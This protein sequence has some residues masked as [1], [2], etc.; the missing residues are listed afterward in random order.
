[1]IRFTGTVKYVDGT[2]TE[3]EAGN[4]ALASWERYALRHGYPIGKDAPPLLSSLVIAHHALGIEQGVD[5]WMETVDGITLDAGDP[6]APAEADGAQT[7]HPTL[8][9]ASRG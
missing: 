3:I 1:M 6:D 7:V 8:A 5:A 2:S 4:A 9:A